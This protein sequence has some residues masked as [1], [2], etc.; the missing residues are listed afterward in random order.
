MQPPN[1][2]RADAKLQNLPEEEL[3]V[4]W[5]F[6]NPEPGGKKLKFSAIQAEIPLRYGF[7]VSGST[8][9]QFYSWLKIWKRWRDA[10]AFAMQARSELAKDPTISDE[11]LDRFAERVLKAE[12]AVTKDV[13]GYVSLRRMKLAETKEARERDKLTLVTKTDLE[14]GLDALAAELE[15]N[16]KA[17]KIYQQL[18][19]VLK[20][21]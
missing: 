11:E 12:A 5:S 4:L 17:L 7:T 16:P 2:P 18:R 8:L 3:L 21:A 13:K 15:G 20:K 14:K 19:E 6:R 10:Q 1:D 9:S